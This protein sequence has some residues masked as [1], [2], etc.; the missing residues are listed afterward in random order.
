LQEQGFLTGLYYDPNG[1]D[2]GSS[3][4]QKN[5]LLEEMDWIR[6]GLAGN[7]S[8]YQFEDRN[9]NLVSSSQVDYNGQPAGYTADPQEVIN[10]IEAHDNETLFDVI[11]LKAPTTTSMADRVRMQALG[12]SVVLLGEGVPFIHAGAELLRSKSL[13]RNSYNSGDWFNKLDFTYN[14]NNWGVGLPPAGDNQ[15][16]WP[17]M[18]PLLGDAALKPAKADILRTFSRLLELLAIRRSTGLFRLRTAA[19]INSRL[20]FYNTGP[21]QTP[22]L[23]VMSISDN[24]GSVDRR[25]KQAVVLF[26]ADKQGHNF[27]SGVFAGQALKLHPI[28]AVSSD[29]L[30]RTASFNSA[31]GTFFVP[32]RTSAVFLQRRPI[33]EQISLL[34]QDVEKLVTAGALNSGQGNALKAKLNAALVQ[35]QRGDGKTT[36]N[37]LKAFT[38]QVQALTGANALSQD[39]GQSL[40]VEANSIIGQ[41]D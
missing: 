3:T 38:N 34:I 6:V 16:N 1:T 18:S 7:V 24:D 9:G 39:Q 22:G 2:Q 10:Y 30:A 20:R 41:L 25:Y 4:D 40:T 31:S 11:Q 28:Q 27:Q 15:S 23:I 29:P 26:N 12:Y 17:L 21:G 8:S 19:D 33:N 14:S 32:E 36:G 35:F 13:D 37:Q 5:R